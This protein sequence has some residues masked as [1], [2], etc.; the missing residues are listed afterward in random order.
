MMQPGI[1]VLETGQVYPVGEREFVIGRDEKADVSLADPLL[2]RRHCVIPPSSAARVRQPEWNQ[3][4]RK[5]IDVLN[6]VP[7]VWRRRSEGS[8][9]S[10]N[11]LSENFLGGDGTRIQAFSE[12]SGRYHDQILLERS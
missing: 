5:S 6:G 9:T 11:G 10:Y 4:E 8:G 12:G 7:Q 2:S 3:A 1:V